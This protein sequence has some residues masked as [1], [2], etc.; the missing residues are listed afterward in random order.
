MHLNIIDYVFYH[1]Y[2][3]LRMNLCYDDCG[4]VMKKELEI[5]YISDTIDYYEYL[6]FSDDEYLE[7]HRRHYEFRYCWFNHIGLSD[8]I[9]DKCYLFLFFS[10]LRTLSTGRASTTLPL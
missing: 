3:Y 9:F 10:I 6:N 8:Y 4:D 2:D 5:G 7:S 1:I